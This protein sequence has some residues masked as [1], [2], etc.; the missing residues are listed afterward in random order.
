M[1]NPMRQGHKDIN[2]YTKN[3]DVHME[4]MQKAIDAGNKE[5][6][7]TARDSAT[8]LYQSF[9]E[10]YPKT[11]LAPPTIPP[12]V[13]PAQKQLIQVSAMSICPG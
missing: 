6:Y 12:F 5:I 2:G 13:T 4:T 3:I 11:E 10:N 8:A 7:D 9:K 1:S